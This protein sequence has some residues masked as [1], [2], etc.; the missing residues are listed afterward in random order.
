M[1]IIIDYDYIRD[2]RLK[3]LYNINPLFCMSTKCLSQL[4][5]NKKIQS[6]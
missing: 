5:I 4:K 6:Y 2:N 3:I 1:Y